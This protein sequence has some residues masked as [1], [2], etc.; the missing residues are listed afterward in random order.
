MNFKNVEFYS[1]VAYEHTQKNPTAV[2]RSYF[3]F[4]HIHFFLPV[5]NHSLSTI[6]KICAQF[7]TEN[8][9]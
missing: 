7:K 4:E 1:L 3:Q 5:L 8:N 9:N 2:E 6:S